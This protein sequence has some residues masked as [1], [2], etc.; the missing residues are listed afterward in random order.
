MVDIARDA[1]W[2]RIAESGGEDPYLGAA[3]ARARVHGFQGDDL[4]APDRVIAC[5]KHWVAY[6]AAEAGRDYNTTDVSEFTLRNVYF[7]P[8][9]AAVD[10]GVGTFMSAFNDL[11]GVPSSAN[12]WT[13]TDV[14][15]KEWQFGGA[16][17]SDYNSVKELVNHAVAADEAD[18]ARLALTAGVDM[19]MVSRSYVTHGPALVKSGAIPTAVLDEAVRR[20]LRLKFR[21]GLFDRPYADASRERDT[22]AKA[23]FRTAAREIAARS[24][25]LLRNQN[26]T[27]PLSSSIRR[28]AVV[29]ALA[30][31]RD[32]VLGNWTGDGR[33][34]DAV[35]VLAG[36]RAALP[37]ADV[38]YARGVPVDLPT[39]T[40][41][42]VVTAAERA[43][44]A[45]AVRL[46]RAADATVLVV[47]EA[48]SMSGEASSRSNIDLP[49]RQLALAR[50]VIATGKP[51]AVVLLNGRPLSILWLA[52]HSP[53]LVEAW[54]PGTEGGHAVAD[55]LLGRVNPGGKLPVTFPRTAGQAP[56]YY[57][58]PP[59]GRPP[60]DS[61]KY[62]SKYLD[63]PWTPL[64]PF[65][66]GLS[67]TTFGY[68]NLQLST[69][70][71]APDGQLTVT[72]TLQN[73]GTRRGDEVAQ[74][75]L[76]DL[77][78]SVSRPVRE[79]KGFTRVTLAAGERRTLTFTLGPRELGYFNREMR[80]AVEPGQF[81]VQVGGDSAEGLTTRFEVTGS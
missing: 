20:V 75:Y 42:A 14:L 73:T 59:T 66:Y 34:A 37:R 48:G 2:G 23:E 62:T 10:A 18:A 61:D 5:A 57:N 74:L 38:R 58:R 69:T 60:S 54:F 19:E 53:A 81:E 52:S 21:A 30:D 41:P 68:S 22:V 46:T 35:T 15:R 78:S 9:K 33:P 79:L 3:I 47:G 11:N 31:S 7:P 55:V 43:G 65:G 56:I 12:R 67:Y 4:S 28:L 71:I 25:V 44:I 64:Y 80:W 49:G 13:L 70:R 32:D 39:L 36:L 77:V 40:A 45:E 8:F 26:G 17:V 51:V 50:A 27:L 16:V 76:R 72:V 29:G 63:V 24:M 1:R 6:G